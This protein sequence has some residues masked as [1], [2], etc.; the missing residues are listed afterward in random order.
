MSL[1]D[2]MVNPMYV[3]VLIHYLSDCTDTC[4]YGAYCFLTEDTKVG[5]KCKS[6]F[7][8]RTQ[9]GKEAV[10]SRIEKKEPK[11]GPLEQVQ[12]GISCLDLI[13]A[14]NKFIDKDFLYQE[15]I[16]CKNLFDEICSDK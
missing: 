10:C 11:L 5:C 3:G 7:R 9:I 6:G 4:G 15:G 8:G 2:E 1:Y 14:C 13:K 12:K 16:K